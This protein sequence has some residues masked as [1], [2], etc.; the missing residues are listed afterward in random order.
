MS[1][2]RIILGDNLAVMQGMPDESVHLVYVD[3]PQQTASEPSPIEV[4]RDESGNPVAVGKPLARR[5]ADSP[6][7]ASGKFEG[8]GAYM[9]FLR[10][11]LK[12]ARRL[13][14][15]NGTL[16]FHSNWREAHYCKILLDGVFGRECFLN[17]IIWARGYGTKQTKKW[18]ARHDTIYVYV[19]DPLNYVFNYE[20][21]GAV[22]KEGARRNP[23][24]VWW[25]GVL[26]KE[27]PEYAG[28]KPLA[29]LERIVAVSSNPGDTV[30]DIFAGSGTT[31]EAAWK[32]G[33]GFVLIDSNPQASVAMTNRFKDCKG[34]RWVN[35]AAKAPRKRGKTEERSWP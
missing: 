29:V 5:E 25:E 11:R 15:P 4:L 10:R 18:P 24:D 32:L 1:S 28:S 19:K 21:L 26:P 13:L 16:Y 8:S 7:L 31:G 14:V 12:E 17:E 22:R 23:T 34:V 9:D 27:G 3:P 35:F 20:A 33:R 2:G 30:L 6:S